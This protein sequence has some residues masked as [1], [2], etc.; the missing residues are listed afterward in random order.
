MVP[1]PCPWETELVIDDH[2]GPTDLLVGCRVCGRAYL[3]EM[4]DWEGSRRLFRVRAPSP[5]AVAALTRDLQRG[6]C[7]LSRAVEE[8]RHVS[9]T[10]DRLPVL[11][12]FD[13]RTGEVVERIPLATPA[14]VP[15]AGWRE[16]PCDGEWIRRLASPTARP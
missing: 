13:T 4:L 11:L 9:L 2:L 10:S 1:G 14:D 3:L 6:S 7:D 15:G 16:L 8:V 12:L 5:G